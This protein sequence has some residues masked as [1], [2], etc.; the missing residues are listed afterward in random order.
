[1]HYIRLVIW[2]CARR[3]MRLCEF[4]DERFFVALVERA[5]N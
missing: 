1:M 2:G 3:L 5:G 4:M